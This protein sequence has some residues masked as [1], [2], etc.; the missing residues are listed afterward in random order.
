MESQTTQVPA[1]GGAQD[2]HWRLLFVMFALFLLGVFLS[3]LY[4]IFTS[5]SGS[6]I[7]PGWFLFSFA[8]GLSMIVLPCTLPLAFVIV[9]LSMGK[10]YVKGLSIALAFGLGVSIT[11]SLYGVFAAILGKAI[12][13]FAGTGGSGEIIKNVF[14]TIAG[15]FAMVFALG[16]LGLV[17]ARMP[18]YMGAAPGFI[19]KRKDVAKAFM[20]G[21]F[22][23]NIGIGCPHPATP[24][25]LGQIGVTGDVFYGWLL[26]F[27]H[28][29]GRI[30]PLLLLAVLGILGVNA[31]K[32]LLKHKDSIAR[33]TAW[34]MVFV[35]AFL[36]TLGFF[37]HDWWVNSGQHTLLE[38][39]TQE[40]TF[41]GALNQ[42]LGTSTTH[43]HGVMAGTGFFGAPL[44][45]GN[46]VFVLLMIIPLWWYLGGEQNRI[47]ALPEAER[48]LPLAK[49]SSKKWSVLLLSGLLALVFVYVLPERFLKQAAEH[50]AGHMQKQQAGAGTDAAH[51]HDAASGMS[52]MMG[53]DH[54]MSDASALAKLPLRTPA[55]RIAKLPFEI[56]EG[57]KEFRLV[58]EEFRWEYAKG[59]YVH[60]WG[61]NGQIPGPEIRVTEGDR[62]RVILENRLPDATAMHWHGIDVPYAQ[63]GVPGFSQT[64]T[65]PGETRV[66]EFE[67]RP[68]GTHFYHTHGSSHGTE[69]MQLDMGL[70]GAFIIEPKNFMRPDKEVTL[71]LDEWAVGAGGMNMAAMA[72]HDS[73][74]GGH[75]MMDYN[76]FTI[77]GRSFPDSEPIMVNKGERVRLRLINAGTSTIH[78]MHLHGHQFK[79]VATDGNAVPQAAQLTK[80]TI[81]LN[82]GETYDIEFTAENPG[83]WV[84]HCHEL[85]HAGAGMIVPVIY[86]GYTPLSQ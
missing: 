9:P 77:N 18:S 13:S 62:V 36:F 37:S 61:Y 55:D 43:E 67:A 64:A 82:P 16:E 59:K 14:Y 56:K 42:Q 58:A 44:W 27:V 15:V 12:Y 8:A 19:Q 32:T 68:A 22:L 29:I 72:A 26:F 73:M 65:Q 25:I 24:I 33:A 50:E 4:W 48:A 28:A 1:E 2:K 46:W 45:L 70:S 60:A 20:L 40:Q 51:T 84:F 71:V 57:V 76:V 86:E 39:I 23:G 74:G 52:V 85:H 80:N 75:A 47:R 21:L 63:D 78:P 38:S 49:F 34:G 31:T 11:L 66:Y 6:P 17:K 7:G 10:G 83:V 30:I 81:A 3:G 54:A 53:M 35:G 41:L 79:I 69:A 5:S